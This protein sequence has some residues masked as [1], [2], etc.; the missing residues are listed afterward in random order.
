MT[1]T[2]SPDGRNVAKELRFAVFADSVRD[3]LSLRAF[4]QGYPAPGALGVDFKA[5]DCVVA[6]SGGRRV[7]HT[8]PGEV[9]SH[10]I[11]VLGEGWRENR[12]RQRMNKPEPAT[13]N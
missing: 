7:F 8:R 12:T 9:G 6:R 1:T 13:E 11:P 3:A 5:V 2:S 4:D 10:D